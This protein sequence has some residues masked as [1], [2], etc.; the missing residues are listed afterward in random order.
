MGRGYDT[1]PVT[2][3]APDVLLGKVIVNS[4]GVAV[5]G[6]MP[7]RGAVSKAL[8]CGESYTVP[9]GYHNGDGTVTANSLSSQTSATATADK[10]LSSETAWV[11]GTK[12]TGTIPVYR[13]SDE[14]ETLIVKVGETYVLPSGYYEDNALIIENDKR[15]FITGTATADDVLDTKT[16]AIDG[17]LMTGTIPT[18]PMTSMAPLRAGDSRNHPSGYYPNEFTISAISLEDQTQGTAVANDIISD[19]TAWVNGTMVTGTIP[20]Y[21][22]DEDILSLESSQSFLVRSGYYPG[23][24][25][26]TADSL[27][28]QT[29]GNAQNLDILID[30]TAWVNGEK[31]TGTM[32]N[33]A[34]VNESLNCGESYT[35]PNGYHNGSG[36]VTANSLS[37]QTIGT[38]TADKILSGETAWVNGEKII[39]SLSYTGAIQKNE[40]L[41]DGLSGS[42]SE[43]LYNISN[44]SNVEGVFISVQAVVSGCDACQDRNQTRYYFIPKTRSIV[45]YICFLVSTDIVYRYIFFNIRIDITSSSMKAFIADHAGMDD[46]SGIT[47]NLTVTKLWEL[48]SI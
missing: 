20:V 45:D 28:S 48:R 27:S 10:I 33:R 32:P 41:Y 4:T 11:N 30:K 46:M 14:G 39:G 37:S 23:N 34:A 44:D 18:I 26:I 47:I 17:E 31:I 40:V 42:S 1:T 5:T 6:T 43:D 2:A 21:Q 13:A 35:V 16:I 24:L 29:Q 3:T 36:T 22:Y 25:T 7:N 8:N 12:I 38:A 19:K 9:N 15:D